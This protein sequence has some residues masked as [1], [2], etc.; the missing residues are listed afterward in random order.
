MRTLPFYQVDVF[1]ERPFAGNPLAIFP[2]ADGL[3]AAQMQAI[4][5]EMNL[6][7]TTFVMQPEGDGHARVR[8]FTPALE[9]P[10]A[11]HPS[12]GTAWEL[13]RL[14]I[15]AAVEPVTRVVLELD[16]G[17]TLVEVE[18]RDGRPL[19]ATVHQGPPTFGA[20][21]PRERVAA[22]LG[23]DLEDLHETLE[24]IPVGTGL[25]Y[26]II[27]LRSQ[28][29]LAHLAPDLSLFGAFER[30]YAEAYPCAFTGQETPWV[31]ARGLFPLSGI[32]EDPATGSAAGPLAAYMARAGLLAAGARRVVLQ[33]AAIGRPSLLTVAVTGTAEHIDNVLVGGAVQ[34]V[35][36]G[37]LTLE[38]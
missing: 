31:E 32:P 7:E 9:L 15:V 30:D 2:G 10:F 17:P 4:A 3:T 23:L 19:A 29:A 8:I 25:T 38:D 11:G 37:E 34:P 35:L 36:R 26:T 5:S 6:S 16:V 12:V 28:R 14:G 13:V 1:T 27:P 33:G 20:P 22:V 21:V 24:A 18:V